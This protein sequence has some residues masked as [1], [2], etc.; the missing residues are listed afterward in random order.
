MSDTI[1]A[2]AT[3]PFKSALALI[4]ITGNEAFPMTQKLF[5]KKDFGTEKKI[6]HGQLIDEAGKQIDDVLLFVYPQQTSMTGED[7]VE[8]SCHGSTL[9]IKEI[10]EAFLKAGARYA[11]PGE[12]TQRSFFHGKMDLV[13]AEAVN[14]LINATTKE[15]KNLA[16][17][18]LG[19]ADSKIAKELKTKLA[20]LL[21]L[22]EVN[23]DFPEYED[24]E[25]ANE[26]VLSAAL[27]DMRE[28]LSKLIKSSEEGRV[29]KEGLTVAIVGEPNVGKSSLLNALLKSDKAIVSSIPG[30]TRDLV[31]GDISLNGIPFHLVDTAGIR[32]AGDAIEA[33]GVERA[34]VAA[35]KADIVILVLDPL[36]SE[37]NDAI[38]PYDISK[39]ICV[40]NKKDLINGDFAKFEGI[41]VSAKNGDIDALKNALIEKAG[42]ATSSYDSPSLSSARCLGLLG[43]IRNLISEAEKEVSEDVPLDLVSAKIAEAY[44]LSQE[45]LGE[46]ISTDLS[47]EIFSRFCVGK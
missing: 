15:G 36:S 47:D 38:I 25:K 5:S 40:Y 13:E 1:I 43:E 21:S 22:I 41:L 11:K 4:R 16:L 32:S 34:I 30:T 19:G 2:L 7:S 33:I 24:I 27:K 28:T 10:V 8:I 44:H 39:T 26:E 23:I 9:I 3:P 37:P 31:E 46:R 6:I 29:I 17:L 45:I 42:V 35:N 18:S 14:D 20:D 12:F